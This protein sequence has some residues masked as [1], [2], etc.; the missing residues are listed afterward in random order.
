MRT[1]T[2]PYLL[3]IFVPLPSELHPF[4]VSM[5]PLLPTPTQDDRDPLRWPVWLKRCALIAA[6]LANF[7]TNMAG[8]GLSVATPNLMHEYHKSQSAA[9]QLL[10]VSHPPWAIDVHS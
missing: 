4:S 2:S 10:I 7:I 8:S 6:S 5:Q 1:K 3:S 9:T